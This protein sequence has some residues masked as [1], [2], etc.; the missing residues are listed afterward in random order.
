MHELRESL[1]EDVET[2]RYG[3]KNLPEGDLYQASTLQSAEGELLTVETQQAKAFYLRGFVGSV[4]RDGCWEPL[5]DSVLGGDNAGMLQWLAAQGFDP[6]TQ[7]ALYWQLDGD[8]PEANTMHIRVQDASLG[9]NTAALDEKIAACFM[10]VEPGEYT[11]VC[12]LIERTIY[13]GDAP[14]LREER[15]MQSFLFK[16]AASAREEPLH[17]RLRLRYTCL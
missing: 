3:E 14:D 13:G 15:A 10:D 11:R 17:T 2:L 8:A 7:S 9:W 5:P 16:L 4:Y 1:T 6:L 12:R